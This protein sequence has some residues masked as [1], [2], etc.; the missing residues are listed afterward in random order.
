MLRLGSMP[1]RVQIDEGFPGAITPEPKLIKYPT[2][3]EGYPKPK[4]MVYFQETVIS[5]KHESIGYF[6]V[7]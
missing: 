2:L 6:G 3:L 7:D 5:E 4:I 1:L